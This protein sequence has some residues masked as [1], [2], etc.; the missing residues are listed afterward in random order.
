VVIIPH[1]SA[2]QTASPTPKGVPLRSRG[3]LK[4]PELRKLSV[5]N[6]KIDFK[7][8]CKLATKIRKSDTQVS[9]LIEVY[10]FFG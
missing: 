1:Q 8:G 7:E 9:L 10:Q 3:S 2:K 4:P 6:A 5:E